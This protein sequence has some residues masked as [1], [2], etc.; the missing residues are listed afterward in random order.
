MRLAILIVVIVIGAILTARFASP[1]QGAPPATTTTKPSPVVVTGTRLT[2]DP[3]TATEGSGGF[4][5]GLGSVFVT[6]RGH[7]EG[8]CEFDYKW[9]VEGAGNYQVYRVSVPLSSGPVVIDATEHDRRD[10]HGWSGGVFTSFT[11]EQAT[12]IRSATFGWSV[13]PLA[14]TKDSVTHR[15]LRPGD[16]DKPLSNGDADGGAVTVRFL[17][18]LPRPDGEFGNLAGEPWQRQGATVPLTGE[19][20]WKW[21]QHLLREMELY[22]IRQVRLPARIG[23]PAARWLPGYDEIWV[24]MQP[25]AIE[26]K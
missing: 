11:K 19:T 14:G 12:L 20:E 6:L 4:S 22:E 10:A 8:R 13:D 5:W 23:G 18:H 25:V 1:A 26:R 21:A 3:K 7:G 16:Q 9:E 24:E 17:V 15:L 2:F